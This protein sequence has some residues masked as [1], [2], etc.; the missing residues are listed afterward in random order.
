M[1]VI[2][3]TLDGRH[4]ETRVIGTIPVTLSKLLS[5]I[6]AYDSIRVN[7]SEYGEVQITLPEIKRIGFSIDP[8]D[9]AIQ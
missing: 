7:S 9:G 3:D 5:N 8:A 4:F 1:I 6:S 2:I